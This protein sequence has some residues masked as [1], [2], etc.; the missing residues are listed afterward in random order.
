MVVDG[1]VRLLVSTALR[2]EYGTVLARPKFRAIAAGARTL[3]TDIDSV[4]EVVE[5]EIV[6]GIAADPDDDMVLG[7]AGGGKADYLVTGNLKDFPATWR[8]T[9]IVN[10]GTFLDIWLRYIV[11][12]GIR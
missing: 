3:L 9:R 8:R 7:C 4:A 12:N 2:A 6:G 1:T 5:P 10:A 11:A